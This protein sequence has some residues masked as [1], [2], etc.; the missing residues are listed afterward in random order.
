MGIE[1]QNLKEPLEII[2]VDEDVLV[3]SLDHRLIEKI[4]TIEDVEF[5]E[6]GDEFEQGA[7]CITIYGS[8]DNLEV[9]APIAGL[10]LEIND[11]FI[12]EINK[13]RK[14]PAWLVKIEAADD[15]DL[16]KFED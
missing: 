5:P 4:G 11:L 6:E 15:T 14:K 16:F 1:E 12:Q 3:L 2:T 7:D 8:D 13:P 10:I 9:R